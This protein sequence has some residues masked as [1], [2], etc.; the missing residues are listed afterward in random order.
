MSSP[1]SNFSGGGSSSERR[2]HWCAQ[3][4]LFAGLCFAA[5]IVLVKLTIESA[6]RPASWLV[7][8]AVA[9]FAISAYWLTKRTVLSFFVVLFSFTVLGSLDYE[10]YL[11]RP[12]TPVPLDIFN[13][14]AEISGTVITS[15][16]ATQRSYQSGDHES[17]ENRQMLDVQ[18]DEI[19]I[20]DRSY[21]TPLGVRLTLYTTLDG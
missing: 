5:G 12:S 21:R 1:A 20:S 10:L 19:N 16:L 7:V 3:P 11:A 18:T 4:M 8:S 17:M 14:P 2:W 6:W 15:N 9:L 13:T